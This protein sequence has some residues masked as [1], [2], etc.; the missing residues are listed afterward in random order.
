M[1]FNHAMAYTSGGSLGYKSELETVI[2]IPQTTDFETLI[3]ALVTMVETYLPDA[4]DGVSSIDITT[5]T[6]TTSTTTTTTT[7]GG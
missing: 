5:T 3:N 1:R 4:I 7:T 2:A 6:T